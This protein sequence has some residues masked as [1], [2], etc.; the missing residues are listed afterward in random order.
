MLLLIPFIKFKGCMAEGNERGDSDL[1]EIIQIPGLID[2]RNRP[3]SRK[4]FR[5][6]RNININ[7]I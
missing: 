7:E 3:T 6:K 1:E 4:R 2:I 5:L